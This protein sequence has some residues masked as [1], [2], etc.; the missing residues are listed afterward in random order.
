MPIYLKTVASN[1]PCPVSGETVLEERTNVL[2]H[3]IGLCLAI[4]GM[5]CM[6]HHTA[7]HGTFWQ[8]MS[9]ALYSS[10]LV[11]TYAISTCYHGCSDL[12]RKKALR[13]AD[14]ICIYFF[15][16]GSYTPF[17]MSPCLGEWSWTLFTL[18]WGIAALGTLWKI[19][20][21]DR[22]RFVSTLAYLTMGWLVVLALDPMVEHLPQAGM[23]WL[24]I[25]GLLYSAGTIFYLWESLPYGHA[26][27]H[28]FCLAGSVC[29]Y[30]TIFF[31]VVPLQADMC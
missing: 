18:V 15:I 12:K 5:G 23:A 25:G 4:L 6:I 30:C 11:L 14:H 9:C 20:F 31:Y 17:T 29:H 3:G 22:F 24:V 8:M 7:L 28:V 21:V 19:F 1:D 16:A 13:I 2:T 10:T 26:I 27:W